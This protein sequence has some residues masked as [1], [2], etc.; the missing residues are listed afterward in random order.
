MPR[1]RRQ[2][3]FS[4]RVQ[5]VGFRYTALALAREFKVGGYVKNLHDGRVELVAQGDE[6]EV[7]RFLAAIE[8]E[9]APYIKDVAC[10]T[11]PVS[12]GGS[13]EF[14]IRH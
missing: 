9:M 5:G 6:T 10:E 14:M 13:S 3:F 12:E 2:V 11:L 4:G 7:D 8:R 1:I